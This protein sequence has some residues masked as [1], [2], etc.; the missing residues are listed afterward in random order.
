M[1]LEL[2]LSATKGC[3]CL[4]ARRYARAITRFYE[5]KLRP[6]GLRATQFSILAALAL[7]G[8]TLVG[9]LADLLGLERTT[10]TRSAALLARNGWVGV[11]RSG[12]ARERPLF[13]T[14]AGRAKLEAAMP[15]WAEAQHEVERRR[16]APPTSQRSDGA[17]ARSGRPS[18][19]AVGEE[20][21]GVMA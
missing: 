10:L 1:P 17:T 5:T 12:D 16:W 14:D 21:G 13:I 19:S 15:S 18:E 3:Y 2:D 8:P 9:E 4:A 20:K 11:R 7:K 6:H